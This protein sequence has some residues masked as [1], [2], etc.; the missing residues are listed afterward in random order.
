MKK[1]LSI[2]IV[3]SAVFFSSNGFSA[4][5]KVLTTLLQS[6]ILQSI[7]NI[8][9]IEVVNTYRCRNCYD[10]AVN[11]VASNGPISLLLHIEEK[12]YTDTFNIKLLSE[13]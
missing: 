1:F 7:A 3:L 2:A 10:I 12:D 6:P 5:T 13:K 11:G 9:S 4:N 8:Q